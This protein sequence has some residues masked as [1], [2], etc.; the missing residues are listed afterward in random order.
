[1]ALYKDDRNFT[2]FVH[3]NL[4][5]PIIYKKLGW[6]QK[7]I[8]P[9]LLE[10]I[11]INEGVDY[12]FEDLNGNEIKSQERFRDNYYAK[13]NDCTLRYKR[14]NNTDISKHKSEFYKVKADFLVY[15]IT[16][17]S[18]F[19]DKRHSLT[20]F[21]K[22]VVL[23]LKV[24]FDK[25]ENGLIIPSQNIGLNS[26]IK[27]NKMFAPI[28]N[29]HDDSSSFVAFDVSLLNQFFGKDK[30]ILFQKGYY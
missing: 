30:I 9:K 28:I 2:N 14:D 25:I 13:Y 6:S 17:G 29:N 20:D 11:D 5:L 16:N 19:Q 12:V 4:A 10:Y 26:Y 8:E 24:L 3:E 15:G 7:Q 27:E 18:K 22:F 1:M 23:D 21:I